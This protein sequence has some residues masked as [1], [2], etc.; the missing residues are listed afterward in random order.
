MNFNEINFDNRKNAQQ[1]IDALDGWQ[2]LKQGQ[3]YEALVH[4]V[5]HVLE[6]KF[7]YGKTHL[8]SAEIVR[9]IKGSQDSNENCCQVVENLIREANL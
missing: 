9:R 7:P 8:I 6:L 3:N 2:C 5:E 4:I 1:V